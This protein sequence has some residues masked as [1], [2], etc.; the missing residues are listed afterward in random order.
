MECSTESYNL[1]AYTSPRELSPAIL[2]QLY[3]QSSNC[4]TI[5]SH[6]FNRG[7][8]SRVLRGLDGNSPLIV[9]A[10]TRH[11]KIA[12]FLFVQ[13]LGVNNKYIHTV[14][15]NP[16]Y[17]RKGC[18]KRLIKYV[19]DNYGANNEL[20][21]HVRVGKV[22]GRGLDDGNLACYCYERYGFRFVN[23]NCNIEN[24][25][26]NCKMIRPV[27]GVYTHEQFHGTS[28]CSNVLSSGDNQPFPELIVNG[29]AIVLI[30]NNTPG[31]TLGTPGS[32]IDCFLR[33]NGRYVYLHHTY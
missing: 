32:D 22:M 24:D 11:N 6:P 18:C 19:V 28:N 8:L 16:I 13:H 1:V 3:R 12:S 21:L 29:R 27:T 7:A 15:T 26:L 2:R 25:G 5:P 17:T 10:D 31:I 20:S 33:D 9:I 4:F 30:K 23:D 14:C